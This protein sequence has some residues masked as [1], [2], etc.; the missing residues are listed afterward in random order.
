MN[1]ATE[2]V[3]KA[4][5][6]IKEQTRKIKEQKIQEKLTKRIVVKVTNKTDFLVGSKMADKRF[7]YTK[8]TKTTSTTITSA[9]PNFS[10]ISQS[11]LK[12]FK[13]AEKS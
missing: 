5:P 1:A 3:Q 10:C 11:V 12:Y 8:T 7:F 13:L 9:V 6:K 4:T 2:H